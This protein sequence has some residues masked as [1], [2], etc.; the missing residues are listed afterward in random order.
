LA[1]GHIAAHLLNAARLE[2]VDQAVSRWE[3]FRNE[4]GPG[5][6]PVELFDWIVLDTWEQFQQSRKSIDFVMREAHDAGYKTVKS[7]YGLVV[8]RR[9]ESR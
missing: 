7:E 5:R 2:P 3:A 8:L 1:T 9:P 6:K 4:V